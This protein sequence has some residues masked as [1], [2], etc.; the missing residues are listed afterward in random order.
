MEGTVNQR[1]SQ[2]ASMILSIRARQRI[3]AGRMLEEHPRGVPD[4]RPDE[5]RES[6]ETATAVVR[7][8]L[9]WLEAHP[10]D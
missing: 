5:A 1:H 10:L 6:V 9:D 7:R 3:H 4:L 2:V 8:I